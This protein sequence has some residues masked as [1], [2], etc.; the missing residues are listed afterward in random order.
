MVFTHPTLCKSGFWRKAAFG[1]EGSCFEK[2]KLGVGGHVHCLG[3]DLEQGI[4]RAGMYGTKGTYIFDYAL[5][6][7]CNV[8][9]F[10]DMLG[11]VDVRRTSVMFYLLGGLFDVGV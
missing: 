2:K 10:E 9:V 4:S 7:A 3:R 5:L 8:A 11:K 1:F 6:G